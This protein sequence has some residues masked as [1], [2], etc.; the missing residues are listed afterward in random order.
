METNWN[1]VPMNTLVM[2][3]DDNEHYYK[4]YF[5][6]QV[7][8]GF[9]TFPEPMN[10]ARNLSDMAVTWFYIKPYDE[11]TVDKLDEEYESYCDGISSDDCRDRKCKYHG[12]NEKGYPTC[13]FNWLLDHYN[14]TEKEV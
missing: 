6:R 8:D 2:V 5:Y 7:E 13:G 10:F 12:F 9:Q 1:L 14:L 3:S 4:G 11:I